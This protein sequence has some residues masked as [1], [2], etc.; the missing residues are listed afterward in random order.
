[1]D[2]SSASSLARLG[3]FVCEAF[4]VGGRL[5]RERREEEDVVVV[6][7]GGIWGRDCEPLVPAGSGP[8]VKILVREV[9]TH[10]PVAWEDI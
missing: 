5:R 1:V 2:V 4:A 10:A 8:L 6:G 7:V 9:G 3:A